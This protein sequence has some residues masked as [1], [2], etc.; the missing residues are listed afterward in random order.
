[1]GTKNKV[2]FISVIVI[3]TLACSFPLQVSVMNAS[4]E[5]NYLATTVV[6]QAVIL[7]EVSKPEP[8]TGGEVP[9]PVEATQA[10]SP[11]GTFTPVPPTA[12]PYYPQRPGGIFTATKYLPVIDGNLD[13]WKTSEY[14]CGYLVFGSSNWSGP[15]DLG[16]TFH[17]SWDDQN[18]YFAVNVMDQTYAQRASGQN[19][20]LGDS[21]E[22]QIDSNLNG[23]FYVNGLDN[24]DYQLGLSPGFI[25]TN[26]VK[27]AVIYFPSTIKGSR[28]QVSIASVKVADGYRLEAAIPWGVWGLAPSVGSKYGFALSVSDNDASY[29]NYQQSMVS[30]TS[31]RKLLNPTTWSELLLSN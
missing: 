15:S 14:Q 5:P 2:I 3:L 12:T 8:G 22:I 7:T 30:S 1:M 28:P 4:P 11:T 29:G 19:L 17:V 31:G 21:I 9:V 26:G 16:C 10:P 25:N 20:Y 27:E 6:A 23:D 18:L 13:E 24:D